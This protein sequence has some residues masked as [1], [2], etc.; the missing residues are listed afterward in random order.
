MKIAITGARGTLGRLCVAECNKQ[1]HDT[2]EINRSDEPADEKN[3]QTE[4]R[5]ADAAN[6]YVSSDL[7]PMMRIEFACT[8]RKTP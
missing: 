3:K 6:S 5:T 4:H 8:G 7:K 2:I 1:G